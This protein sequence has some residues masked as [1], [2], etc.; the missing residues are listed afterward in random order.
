MVQHPPNGSDMF[1]SFIFDIDENVIEVYYHKDVKLFYQ[2][3][4]DVV[5]K[6]SWYISQFKRYHLIFKIAITGLETYLLFI[7]FSDSYLMIGI[8]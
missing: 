4:I 3:L 1:F 5:L 2:N 6:R 7:F 8:N